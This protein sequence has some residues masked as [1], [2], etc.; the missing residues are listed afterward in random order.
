MPTIPHLPT[1]PLAQPTPASRETGLSPNKPWW[2]NFGTRLPCWPP[3][4]LQSGE[5]IQFDY[6]LLATGSS[7]PAA[8]KPPVDRLTDQ[9][10]RLKAMSEVGDMVSQGAGSRGGAG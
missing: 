2:S 8:I 3:N 5:T 7:Y 6:A 10:T 4:A 1:H 9:A